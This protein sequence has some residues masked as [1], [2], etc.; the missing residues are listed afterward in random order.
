MDSIKSKEQLSRWHC[1]EFYNGWVFSSIALFG[2]NNFYLK[3]AYGN[4]LTG[5]LSDLL[6]CFFLPLF[7]CAVLQWFHVH[8]KLRIVI[9]LFVTGAV[10]SLVKLNTDASE[11]LKTSLTLI[12]QPLGLGA[13]SNQVD[14]T[15]LIAL[16]VLGVTY[17]FANKHG[18]S[19]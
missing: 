15:D 7:I 2:L 4:W 17:W 14:P 6:V 10:L 8:F 9:G 3:A 16:P 19:S 18:G 13:S 11:L 12:G 1:P 5:K